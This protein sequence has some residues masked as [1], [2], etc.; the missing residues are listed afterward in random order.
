MPGTAAA[1]DTAAVVL[2]TRFS[3]RVTGKVL[4]LQ[5]WKS[6]QM[7]GPFV[8]TLWGP[9]GQV[10]ATATVSDPVAQGWQDVTFST[11]ADVTAGQEYTV[12]YRAPSGRYPV[13]L[14]ALGAARTVGDLTT[15]QNAG[16]Y[17]Y[18]TGR[19]TTQT[20][21]SY[22]VD[23]QFEPAATTPAVVSRTPSGGAIDVATGTKVSVTTSQPL[24]TSGTTLTLAGPGNQAVSG[25]LAVSGTT[26]TL[27]PGSALQ[28]GTA[29][30]ASFTGRTTGGQTIAASSWSFTTK[31]AD[32][33]CPC[34]I[35]GSD[36]PPQASADDG[37]AV[38]LGTRFSA[39][40][41]GYVTA[42]R[43]YRGP[44]NTG[45][46]TV[47]VWSSSG[48]RLATAQAPSG[49]SDGWQTVTLPQRVAVTAGTTYTVSY[50]A[51]NGGYAAGSGYFSQ[52]RTVGPLTAP[53][54]AGTYLYGGGYPQFTWQSTGYWVDPV[55]TDQ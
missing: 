1:A 35:F 6:T 8:A 53:V 16:V 10:V 42:V 44:A 9:S 14:G 47:S 28:P 36:V 41:A 33:Q 46:Q 45:T 52:A 39:N 21:T 3:P 43:F 2:G 38:E 31:A 17:T 12:G 25:S 15:P 51:P 30:T 40:R 13:T 22:S 24:A 11:P 4:G 20:S 34:T 29:Y 23:V 50:L 5:F 48:T 54:N 37:A 55:F 26:A 18:G 19:P 7:T 49:G 32:G 27:T